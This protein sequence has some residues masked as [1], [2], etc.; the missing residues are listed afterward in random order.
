MTGASQNGRLPAHLQSLFDLFPW[1]YAFCRDHLFRDD[2][3]RITASL[4]TAGVPP[5]GSRLLELGS[6]DNCSFE[7]GDARAYR[8]PTPRSTLW[9]SR[10]SSSSCP[11][12]SG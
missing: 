12:R 11:N 10:G 7:K 6:L 8:P 3:G 5:A 9:S 4:W 1:L 2:T